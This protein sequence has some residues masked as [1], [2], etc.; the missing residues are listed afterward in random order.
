LKAWLCHP[1]STA[2]ST[3]KVTTAVLLKLILR[4]PAASSYNKS[5]LKLD[6]NGPLHGLVKVSFPASH[7]GKAE[8]GFSTPGEEEQRLF[9]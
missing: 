9:I 1:H 7:G 5:G 2:F 3:E 6:L 4:T 8:I